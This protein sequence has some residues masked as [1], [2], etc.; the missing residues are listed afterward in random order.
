MFN[1]V[2]NGTLVVQLPVE[3]EVEVCPIHTVEDRLVLM[4][5]LM[6]KVIFIQVIVSALAL[7]HYTP[8]QED[9]DRQVIGQN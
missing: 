1:R 9:T 4:Q 8:R 3:V 6:A 5:V 2:Q 7:L